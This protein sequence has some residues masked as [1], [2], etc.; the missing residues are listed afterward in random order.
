MRR[1]A[2]I[3]LLATAVVSTV[4]IASA[5]HT[6]ADTPSAAIRAR[7]QLG[8]LSRRSAPLFTLA[9]QRDRPVSLGSLRGSVVVLSFLDPH[10]VDVCPVVS[11]EFAGAAR[12]LAA[13][14][15]HIV[16]LAVNVNQ[17]HRRVAD[18]A[19]FSRLH[20]LDAVPH[21]HFLT[22]PAPLL[23]KVWRSYGVLVEPNRSGDVVHSSLL[24]FID[25]AG[26][27]RWVARPSAN[28]T[29]ATRWARDI[30]TVV[31]SLA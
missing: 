28:K 5:R 29:T 17:F 1:V 20:G 8:N 26:H 6:S 13:S 7:M 21:W 23:R 12:L 24:Y 10:C 2:A 11:G 19:A 9:D 4:S 14:R 25:P 15:R 3:A 31:A 30:A 16:F 18:V 22:G 27:E